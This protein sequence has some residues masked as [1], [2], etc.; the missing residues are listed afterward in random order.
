MVARAP[1]WSR[2]ELILALDLY[3]RVGKAR[4]HHPD[5]VALSQI[6]R[7]A[8]GGDPADRSLRSPDS[9]H[10]KLQ[11]FLR[12][13]PSYRGAGMTGG[14]RLE[15]E[16]WADFGR[17]RERLNNVANT[18]RK[19][20]TGSRDMNGADVDDVEAP[21]GSLLAQY[22]RSRERARGLV[23]RKKEHAIR[24]GKALACEVCDFCFAVQYGE[25]GVGFIECHHR[26]P[27]SS[28][29][30]GTATKLADLA[31]VCSNCHSMLH[32]GSPWPSVEEL[33]RLLGRGAVP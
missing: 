5:V 27:L 17:D 31:L 28:L 16:V 2:D 20:I 18:I 11:N 32:R 24:S 33:R 21:E 23:L 3:F 6:L 9:V 8:L 1:A 30:P 14:G 7:S 12:L 4:Q 29:S 25:R 13:D 15:A 22:H 10:L 26:Q 19:I